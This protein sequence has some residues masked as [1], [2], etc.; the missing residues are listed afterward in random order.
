VLRRRGNPWRILELPQQKDLDS[1]LLSPVTWDYYFDQTYTEDW[2][3]SQ[4]PSTCCSTGTRAG[5]VREPT[6]IEST[7]VKGTWRWTLTQDS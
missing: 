1:I 3:D 7:D 4:K 6:R 5:I 2:F